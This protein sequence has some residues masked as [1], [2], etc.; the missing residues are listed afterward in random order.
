MTEKIA[1]ELRQQDKLTGCVTVKI[2]Y[3]DFE[4]V[5]KQM[6]IPYSSSDHV[7]LEKVKEL[8]TKLYDRRLLIRLIGVRFSHLVHG[9]HQISLF[10]DTQEMISLYQAID[11]IKNRFGWQYLMRGTNAVPQSKKA[12]VKQRDIMPY[13]KVR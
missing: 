3:S 6:T 7:L 11:N 5:T 9:N 4:T 2:R 12:D 8:F 10:D 13:P 1:F